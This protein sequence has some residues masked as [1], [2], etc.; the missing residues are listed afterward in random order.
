MEFS[1]VTGCINVLEVKAFLSRF[2]NTKSNV[3]FQLLTVLRKP[4]NESTDF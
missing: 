2:Q 3:F 1:E 4:V